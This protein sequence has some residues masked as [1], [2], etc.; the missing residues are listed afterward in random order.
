MYKQFSHHNTNVIYNMIDVDFFL[1]FF[2]FLKL[3]GQ[4]P[5]NTRRIEKGVVN[6]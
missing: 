4:N 1:L 3:L 2:Y 6:L 5:D